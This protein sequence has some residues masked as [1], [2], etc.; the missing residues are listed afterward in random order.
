MLAGDLSVPFA[1]ELA[2]KPAGAAKN[3]SVPIRMNT[4]LAGS[5]PLALAQT[6]ET[7]HNNSDKATRITATIAR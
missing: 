3:P 4:E 2:S 7:I 5:P 6:A 1:K